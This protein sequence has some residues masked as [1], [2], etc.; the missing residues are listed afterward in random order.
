MLWNSN[1]GKNHAELLI[2]SFQNENAKPQN[3]CFALRVEFGHIKKKKK[4][5]GEQNMQKTW[6]TQPHKV[7]VK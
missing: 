2:C 6:L 5:N 4:K 7:V 3:F 1:G